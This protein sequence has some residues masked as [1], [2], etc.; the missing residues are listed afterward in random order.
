MVFV[1]GLMGPIPFESKTD[2][3]EGGTE[4]VADLEGLFEIVSGL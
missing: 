2:D 4:L 3:A 1:K